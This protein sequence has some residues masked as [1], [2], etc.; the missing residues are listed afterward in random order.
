[1]STLP[2]MKQCCTTC[3]FKQDANG[4]WQNPTLASEV[5][6]RTLFQAQQI[7]HG[8]EGNNREPRNRCKGA[9]DQNYVIYERIGL[10]PEKHLE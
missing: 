8:T 9:Y 5:M 4:H 3:P 1:M 2:I 10:E 6:T 7:C